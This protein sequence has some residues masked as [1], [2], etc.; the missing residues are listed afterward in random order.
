ML[1]ALIVYSYAKYHPLTHLSFPKRNT[2]TTQE[3]I[4]RPTGATQVAHRSEVPQGGSKCRTRQPGK[5]FVYVI[6]A[7][8]GIYGLNSSRNPRDIMPEVH[9]NPDTRLLTDSPLRPLCH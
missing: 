6:P 5:S 3:A 8:A 9:P 2:G 1:S 4:R 7:K